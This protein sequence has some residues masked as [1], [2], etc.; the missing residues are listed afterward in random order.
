M[1][2]WFRTNKMSIT[3]PS[4]LRRSLII[5]NYSLVAVDCQDGCDVQ[6]CLFLFL[7]CLCCSCWAARSSSNNKLKCPRASAPG[8]WKTN[9]LGF[10]DK[11]GPQAG[12]RQ[13]D[14]KKKQHLLKHRHTHLVPLDVRHS[15]RWEDDVHD[16]VDQ[17]VLQYPVR[18]SGGAQ[19][20]RGVDLN[21][22][23]FEVV[24]YDDVVAVALVTMSVT[25]LGWEQ[26]KLW[27][28]NWTMRN[29]LVGEKIAPRLRD[30]ASCGPRKS[31]AGNVMKATL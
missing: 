11:I 3:F 19:A 26:D 18:H 12:P 8:I 24:V 6:S 14:G 23:R 13:N 10:I 1:V 2:S 31:E 28:R 4:I 16:V 25:N 7:F 22:P 30:L 27:S 21:E 17:A 20:G 5:T 29:H 15:V 9:V